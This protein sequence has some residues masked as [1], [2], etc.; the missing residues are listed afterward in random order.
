MIYDKV[1]KRRRRCLKEKVA[2]RNDYFYYM[3][4]GSQWLAYGNFTF[5][6]PELCLH[7][8]IAP[9]S[10]FSE[11]PTRLLED[12][13]CVIEVSVRP[14]A[15]IVQPIIEALGD[16]DL[17]ELVMECDSLFQ[18]DCRTYQKERMRY[19]ELRKEK[20]DK[21]VA[22]FIQSQTNTK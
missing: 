14:L 17:I 18:K 1:T 8:G 7:L 9:Q 22:A 16:R 2:F 5:K 19:N 20:K 11:T 13:R 12:G 6:H 4:D 10:I 3:E 21:Q 15:E